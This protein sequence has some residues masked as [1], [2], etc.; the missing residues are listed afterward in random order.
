MIENA[1]KAAVVHKMPT[2]EKRSTAE[3]R[4]PCKSPAIFPGE[5]VT[6]MDQ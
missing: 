3:H 4:G 1:S 6:H 5:K 2:T